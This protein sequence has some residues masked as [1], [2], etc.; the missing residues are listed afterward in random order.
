MIAPERLVA[1]SPEAANGQP[2]HGPLLNDA[3]YP[4]S[5]DEPTFRLGLP[6]L[7]RKELA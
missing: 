1:R 7:L 3:A 4:T 2:Q 5:F 6:R